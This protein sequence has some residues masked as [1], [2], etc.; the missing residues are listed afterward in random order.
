MCECV[1]C[2]QLG[3][4]SDERHGYDGAVLVEEVLNSLVRLVMGGE[5]GEVGKV[6]GSF[7]KF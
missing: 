2:T 7:L 4:P 3:V 1:C 6:Q 5:R